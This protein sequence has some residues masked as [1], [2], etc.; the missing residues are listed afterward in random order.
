MLFRYFIQNALKDGRLKFVDKKKYRLEKEVNPKVNE[1]L[2]VDLVDVLMVNV[3][4]DT[5]EAEPSYEEKRKMVF[6]SL[7]KSS[8]IF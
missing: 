7:R 2:F 4:K 5:K 1:V 3:T 8:L 6:P